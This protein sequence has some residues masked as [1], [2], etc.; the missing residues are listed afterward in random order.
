MKYLLNFK[1]F[2][3]RQ[4]LEIPFDG[5][6]PLHDKPTHVHVL[7]ALKRLAEDYKKKGLT[8]TNFETEVDW[9][10]LWDEN[11][12]KAYL[13]W[14]EMEAMNGNDD[15]EIV[16]SDM[17]RENLPLHKPEFYNAK[18]WRDFPETSGFTTRDD[19]LGHF[20]TDNWMENLTYEL[21]DLENYLT[22]EGVKKLDQYYHQHYEYNLETH[23][24]YYNIEDED[25]LIKIWQAVDYTK[26]KDNDEFEEIM[27]YQGVGVYWSWDEG[28]AFPHGG[29]SVGESTFILHGLVRP[30]D[31]FWTST[32]WKNAS[33]LRD[34]QEI[35]V[36]DEAPILIYGLSTYNYRRT[37]N[38]FLE[39]DPPLVVPA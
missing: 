22:P 9:H 34:E 6:D 35:E 7:D 13:D 33:N 18:F 14:Y 38:K 29:G 3:D 39:I 26:G 2:E 36:N 1:L 16:K 11:V 37:E 10:D 28:V 5:K 30:E 4:Q 21:D 15:F 8:A 31:V 32:I 23:D 17:F 25:G 19:Y 24:P 12:K 27:K 20:I